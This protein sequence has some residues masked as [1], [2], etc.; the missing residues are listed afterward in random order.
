MALPLLP[1]ELQL[2]ILTLAAPPP[3]QHRTRTHSLST[4]SL[5]CRAWRSPAQA[6]L[7][8]H[9]RYVLHWRQ[10]G[11]CVGRH[12]RQL[13]RSADEYKRRRLEERLR[14]LRDEK[15]EVRVTE[16]E[17]SLLLFMMPPRL[18]GGG[19]DD[20]VVHLLKEV[21]GETV[22]SLVVRYDPEG[23]AVLPSFLALFSN[24]KRLRLQSETM[25]DPAYLPPLFFPPATSLPPS[26]AL[27]QPLPNH[28]PDSPPAFIPFLSSLTHLTLHRL[29]FERFPPLPLP[30]LRSLILEAGG[31][32]TSS[33]PPNAID[34]LF[35]WT[36]NLVVF[37]WRGFRPYP[38]PTTF[39]LAPL[40]LQDVNVHCS[41][42]KD[43]KALSSAI[44]GYSASSLRR[45]EAVLEPECALDGAAGTKKAKYL[46][47]LQEWCGA[48]GTQLAVRERKAGEGAI[49]DA[50]DG[51]DEEN[52]E[53]DIKM[54]F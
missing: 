28:L 14:W 15:G 53:D 41:A 40:S 8:G 17:V 29:A 20:E 25:S 54:V 38:T 36:P 22:E 34:S 7:L 6:L 23:A 32:A 21:A 30:S 27:D 50:E 13:G 39:A 35:S 19:D 5:V 1:L 10:Y 37:T 4:L 26:N 46:R 31:L 42:Y 16:L 49:L 24:L 12:F 51:F 45:V 3:S 47:R 11:H 52:E 2:H 43:L 9:L 33:L 18:A 48:A 44:R